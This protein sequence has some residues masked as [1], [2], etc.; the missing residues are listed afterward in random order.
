ALIE[1]IQMIEP[2]ANVKAAPRQIIL[3]EFQKVRPLPAPLQILAD[4][5]TPFKAK[6]FRRVDHVPVVD[7]SVRELAYDIIKISKA[8]FLNLA[9]NHVR[10]CN[11][12][13]WPGDQA[14]RVFLFE[15]SILWQDRED[16]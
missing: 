9:I 6:L 7:S 12:A 10:C 13:H 8:E 14:Q 15:N 4:S 2:Q 1:D 11:P 3:P 5:I 16:I